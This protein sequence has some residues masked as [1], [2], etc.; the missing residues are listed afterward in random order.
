M[1]LIEEILGSAIP[2]VANVALLLYICQRFL[3]ATRQRRKLMKEMREFATIVHRARDNIRY[4][5]EQVTNGMEQIKEDVGKELRVTDRLTTQSVK[6]GTV[7]ERF[8]SLEENVIE[9]VRMDRNRESV[10]IE[11]PVNVS[12]EIERIITAMAV[13][14][15]RSKQQQKRGESSKESSAIREDVDLETT[16]APPPRVPLSKFSAC[17]PRESATV[18][19]GQKTRIDGRARVITTPE[20]RLLGETK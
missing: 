18:A 16:I 8:A 11:T 3:A 4:I 17:N 19:S 20:V 10:R 2:M 13:A 7:L 15:G 1:R 9:L 6:L 5:G 14:P 12:E